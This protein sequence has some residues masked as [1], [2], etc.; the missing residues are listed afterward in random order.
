MTKLPATY[1][2]KEDKLAPSSDTED[3][4]IHAAEDPPKPLITEIRERAFSHTKRSASK[5]SLQYAKKKR[6]K[7]EQF[8][9][10]ENVSVN[11]PKN[12]RV[13]T[14]LPRIP[15]VITKVYEKSDLYEVGTKYGI[16]K[17]KIRAGDL[18]R[19][20]DRIACDSTKVVSLHECCRLTNPHNK[21]VKKPCKCKGGCKNKSCSCVANGIRCSTHCHP[22]VVCHNV[23]GPLNFNFELI[24]Q[25]KWL[26]DKEMVMA[27]Q[28]LTQKNPDM[29]GLQD[30]VL[31]QRNQWVHPKSNFVQFLHVNGNHWIAISNIGEERG[32]V[33]NLTSMILYR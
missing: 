28:L 11:V 25:R 19:Y 30:L 10:G 14:D 27:A 23:K 13:A 9:V 17:S 16:F 20:T 12:E 24:S 7:V 18:Q 31:G 2:I 5:M 33:N 22:S 15:G 1:D 3:E 29:D 6:M 8:Q 4:R 26:T 21:F 32:T